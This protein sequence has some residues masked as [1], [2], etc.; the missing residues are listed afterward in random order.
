MTTVI[1]ANIKEKKMS[2]MWAYLE[3]TNKAQNGK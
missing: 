2:D 3:Q 1:L